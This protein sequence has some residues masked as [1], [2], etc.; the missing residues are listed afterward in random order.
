MNTQG[1]PPP[2]P[3]PHG[4]Q[5]QQ[6]QQHQRSSNLPPGNYDIFVIPPHSSGSGFLYL[7]S[8]Q[9]QRNSF[10][11]GVVSTLLVLGIWTLVEP[12]LKQWAQTVFATGG[13]GVLMLVLGVGVIGWAAGKTQMENLNGGDKSAG[14]GGQQAGGAGTT[15]GGFEQAHTAGAHT[16]TGPEANQG[17]PPPFGS[18]GAANAGSGPGPNPKPSWQ[19]GNTTAGW[20]KARAEMRKKE[21]ERKKREEADKKAKEAAEKQKWEQ[22]RQREREQ[23]EKEARERVAQERLKRE[24]E[25]K[26]QKEKQ[27]REAR[28]RERAARE[29]Q[30][31]SNYKKPTASSFVSSEEQ[32]SHR[33][34]DSKRPTKTASQ[35]SFISG[36]EGS[37][38]T[39][40]QSTA[41]TTP[42]PSN[43]GPYVNK[44]PDKV[45]IRGVFMFTDALP[46]KPLA[47]LI[48]GLGS[49]T[50]GLV[51]KMTTEGLFIDDDVRGVPQREWD[52]K[53]WTM[54]LVE[55]SARFQVVGFDTDSGRVVIFAVN[56]SFVRASEMQKTRSMSSSSMS[57]KHGRLL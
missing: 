4:S 38:W 34:Y 8:L 41:R 22:S 40:S 54:K 23:R 7:P 9:V 26:E 30:Q 20:E 46:G 33:P 19:Q 11:A 43:R 3:P 35:S 57:P 39:G 1:P 29:K 21:E 2:P 50:D 55:V 10:L 49:V 12:V 32:H 52:V 48:S 24:R 44:D 14:G 5:N 51:L 36:S 17:A 53:A 13:T 25:L 18:T 6:Q 45:T 31:T 16:H 42:P 15:A 56:M 27:E 28:E 47:Q 37:S